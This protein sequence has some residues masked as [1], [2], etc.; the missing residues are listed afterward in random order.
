MKKRLLA[1]AT[2]ATLSTAGIC[3]YGATAAQAECASYTRRES[4]PFVQVRI[5]KYQVGRDAFLV[6]WNYRSHDQAG[7]L[8]GQAHNFFGDC[9]YP[10]IGMGFG[11]GSG[12]MVD[13]E[14][15]NDASVHWTIWGGGVDLNIARAAIYS[16][17]GASPDPAPFST[18]TSTT[19][20]TVVDN[21]P[22]LLQ[23]SPSSAV[24]PSTSTTVWVDEND[25]DVIDE[26]AELIVNKYD[27]KYYL[28]VDSSY[29]GKNMTV[30][31]RIGAR[32]AVIW[33]ITTNQSGYR[34]IITTRN[35]AGYAISLWVDGERYDLVTPN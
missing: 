6:L 17:I 12:S 9:S 29:P 35:L 23:N 8:I 14:Y 22:Q 3:S 26:Y 21:S 10:G 20:T 19:T 4:T 33:N 28:E 25:G 13:G 16:A 34:R 15:S 27:S 5:Y 7:M 2:S 1:V 18:S 32:C 31:A 30:R 11:S 24:S